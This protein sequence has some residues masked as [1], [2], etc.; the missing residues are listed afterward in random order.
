MIYSDLWTWIWRWKLL[1]IWIIIDIYRYARYRSMYIKLNENNH[2][3]RDT[4]H[5]N[6]RELL[7]DLKQYPD[8]LTD[9]IHDLFFNKITM[10]DMNFDEVCMSLFEMIGEH[11]EYYTDIVKLLEEYKYL[12][13]TKDKNVFGGKYKH[14]RIKHNKHEIKCWF[15][16]LPIYLI[17]RCI[18]ACVFVYMK[19]LGFNCYIH[20]NGLKIWHNTYDINKGDPIVFFHASVGGITV[21]IASISHLYNNYNIIMPEIPGVAFF[22]T[23]DTKDRPL[24]IS[25]IID[26][27]QEFLL[28]QYYDKINIEK[29]NKINLMGHSLG[30]TICSAYINRHPQYISNFFCIE[31]QIFFPRALRISEDFVSKIED[32]PLEDLITVPLFHRDLYVQ[33]FIIKRLTIDSTMI[34][35]MNDEKSHI[36]IHMY[37]VKDDRRILIEEQLEYASRKNIQLEYHIFD[38]DYLHGSFAMNKKIRNYVMK[39]IK[40]I[41]KNNNYIE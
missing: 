26:T 1:L 40:N 4:N 28:E 20:E 35:N 17:T 39:D 31:G 16:I 15:T 22:D 38:G 34:Y 21:Q 9:L 19:I 10:E 5:K 18:N 41:Y 7:N 11:N 30:C 3:H 23:K 29:N 8:I 25:E 27:V 24:A 14:E 33:Y 37:H 36:K 12:S 2:E 6:I 13:I 32:I